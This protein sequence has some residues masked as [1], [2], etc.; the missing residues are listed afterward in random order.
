MSNITT[1]TTAVPAKIGAFSAAVAKRKTEMGGDSTLLLDCSSSMAAHVNVELKGKINAERRRIDM[2][3][4]VV[5]SIRLAK[6]AVRAMA[7]GPLHFTATVEYS[8]VRMLEPG[9]DIPEP[10][11]GTPLAEAIEAATA[12]GGKRLV[13]ISDGEPNDQNRAL[14]A[15]RKHGHRIDCIFIGPDNAH[16]PGE[17]FLKRLADASGGSYGKDAMTG[18]TLA[19]E[20]KIIGLLGDGGSTVPPVGPIAL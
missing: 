13:V 4:R 12:A 17:D 19:L 14:E 8:S 20:N 3:R 5:K 15:A 10:S 2:L 16:D 1:T 7:F 11:G 6:P 18:G 9:E